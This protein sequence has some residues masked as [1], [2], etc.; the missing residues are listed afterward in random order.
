MQT[1]PYA[2]TF[3]LILLCFLKLQDSRSQDTLTLAHDRIRLVEFFQSTNGNNWKI[4]TNWN[5]A[6]DVSTWYGV[7]VSGGR[8]TDINLTAN[9]VSGPLPASI[10]NLSQLR[11][12]MLGQNL[13]TGSIP[14]EIGNIATLVG[15]NL[16][17]NQLTGPLPASMGNLANLVYI[18]LGGNQFTGNIPTQFGNLASIQS[19]YLW[20][21]QLEG[22]L[23]P[24]LG[25]LST[26]ERFHA[27]G[28]KL[29]GAVPSEFNN[30]DALQELVLSNNSLTDLPV[31][32]GMSSITMFNVQQ[33]GFTFADIVPNVGVNG[34]AYGSQKPLPFSG[35]TSVIAGNALVLSVALAEAGNAVQWFKN[36]VP[37]GGATTTMLNIP[38][39]SGPDAGSYTVEITNPSAPDLVIRGGTDMSPQAVVVVYSP[40]AATEAGYAK[41]LTLGGGSAGYGKLAANNN[42]MYVHDEVTNTIIKFNYAGQQLGTVNFSGVGIGKISCLSD[43][44]VD[45]SD[46]L[47]LSSEC[48]SKVLKF[49]ASGVFQYEILNTQQALGLAV[50]GANLHVLAKNSAKVSAYNMASGTFSSDFT[51]NN[52]PTNYGLDLEIDGSGNYW[53][54]DPNIPAIYKFSGATGDIDVTCDMSSPSVGLT[55]WSTF[56]FTIAG[57]GNIYAQVFTGSMVQFDASGT[58]IRRWAGDD[59]LLDPIGISATSQG[60]LVA[61]KIHGL[62]ICNLDGTFNSRIHA[63]NA[64]TQ[65]YVPKRIEMDSK[66]NR[67]VC[68]YY[69]GRIKKYTSKGVFVRNI[70]SLGTG[71]D[72][73]KYPQSIAIARGVNGADIIYVSDDRNHR[74]QMYSPDG[75]HLGSIGGLGT[76]DGQFTTPRGITISKKGFLYVVDVGNYRI[77]KFTR[78]GAFVKSFGTQGS[79]AGQFTLPRCIASE[80]DGTLLIT[81]GSRLKRFTEEGNFV[82]EVPLSGTTIA[83][84]ATDVFGYIYASYG[85]LPNFGDN[86]CYVNKLDKNGA[87]VTMIPNALYVSS[88]PTGD[89]L[90][91]SGTPHFVSII[92]PNTK[93]PAPADRV[94]LEALYNS[95]NGAQWTTGTNWMT[96]NPINTWYG[97]RVSGGKVLSID[98]KNNNLNGTI[99]PSLTNL[100]TLHSLNLSNN[101]LTGE[102]PSTLADLTALQQLNVA[103]NQ[104]TGSIPVLPPQ[105]ET[106]NFENNLFTALTSVPEFLRSVNVSDND[107]ESL[108]NL[109]GKSLENLE[110]DGNNLSFQ[111]LAQNTSIG[112]FDYLNQGLIGD[113][114]PKLLDV[115]SDYQINMTTPGLGNQYLWRKVVKGDTLVINGATAATFDITS[116]N[117]SNMG[118]Y[119]IEVTNPA[120]PGLVIKSHPQSVW[121]TANLQGRLLLDESN[122]APVGTM[123][124]YDVNTTPFT[125]TGPVDVNPDGTYQFPKV[126]LG[127]Y[128][129]LGH[130]HATEKALPTYYQRSIFWELADTLFINENRNDLDIISE[131]KPEPPQAGNGHIGGVFF[132]DPE[133]IDGR[134]QARTPVRKAGAS[135]SRGQSSGRQ[136][137]GAAEDLELVAYTFTNDDGEFSFE[138]LDPGTYWLNLQYPGYPMDSTSYIEVTVG[139]GLRDRTQIVEADVIDEKIFVRQLIIL[140]WENPAVN[141]EAYPNPASAKLNLKGIPPANVSFTVQDMQ[142]KQQRCLPLYDNVEKKWTIDLTA[143]PKGIYIVKINTKSETRSLKISIE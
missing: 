31:L 129:L 1:F 118:V 112:S 64:N 97:V 66:Y 37:I 94:I 130:A 39:A 91:L 65:F 95:T 23:P 136:Q 24:Q 41:T 62:E 83:E 99:P 89:T 55:P 100:K 110:V 71:T 28:N 16:D 135:V 103:N 133:L 2:K 49:N 59:L 17:D 18:S 131:F 50:S 106:A 42:V 58:F 40:D 74:I 46:A 54:M 104:L 22:N 26:L 138:N 53:V 121:A 72:Q 75:V 73:L 27:Q 63:R 80:D 20:N 12:L 51:L 10:G 88:N 108:G 84:L 43:M 14:T 117:R 13:I 70:G 57:N 77:Q 113:P 69:N 90:W 128:Q 6:A 78:D 93:A 142:G 60:L 124:L 123:T 32:T 67:Y 102:L 92:T 56:Y 137:E 87:L 98:L 15:I 25:N 85:S 114:E 44:E 52:P 38:S 116:I 33:N 141:I 47:Y 139:S 127:D 48:D 30:L 119:L 120:L 68:D 5:T 3:A 7:T 109:A 115:G 107:L 34:F 76:G 101:N 86:G 122:P 45:G 8:V 4:K 9:N 21:N 126:I 36:G 11:N 125:V 132:E 81:D 105:L 19:I 140:G 143:M 29:T 96:N 35:S 79:G 82:S 134:P 61:D 111:D